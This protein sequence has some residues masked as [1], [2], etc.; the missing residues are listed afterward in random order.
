MAVAPDAIA[1][2][3]LRFNAALSSPNERVATSV[4]AVSDVGWAETGITWNSRPALG[5][6]LGTTTVASGLSLWHEV[7]VTDYLMAVGAGGKQLVTL[8]L[9]YPQSS[10]AKLRVNSRE[11]LTDRPELVVL[12]T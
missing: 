5:D 2:V 7:D 12:A 11:A 9:H 8:A 4:F 3:K 6:S 1:S 10:A